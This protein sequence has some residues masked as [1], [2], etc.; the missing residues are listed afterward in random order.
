MKRKAPLWL[1][2]TGLAFTG[3]PSVTAQAALDSAKTS[4]SD[5]SGDF[6]LQKVHPL[7]ESKCF[8]CHG[9]PKDREAEFDMRT[10]EGL[11]KGGESG[12]AGLVPGAPD[13]SRMFQAVMRQGK[14][15]MPPKDRNKL[16]VAE[17]EILR[18][19]IA[20][21]APWTP[22]RIPEWKDN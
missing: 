3:A 21:G 10:R 18:R 15:K 16:S 12:K 5:D 7:L 22:G 13:K 11:V 17:I 19:W 1:I 14:L 20:A 8:G 6:F 2:A 9:E 4:A